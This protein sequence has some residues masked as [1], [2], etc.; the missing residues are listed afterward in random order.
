MAFR[1][2]KSFGF[3]GG[4]ATCARSRNGLPIGAILD[5]AGMKH[6]RDIGARPTMR[7]DV[8]VGV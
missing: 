2:E 6:A 3:N 8:P 4:H 1:F 7:D 5:V